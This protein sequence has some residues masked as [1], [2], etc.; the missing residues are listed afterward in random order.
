MYKEEWPAVGDVVMCRVVECV[1]SGSYVELLEYDNIIGM[2]GVT[3]YS[4]QRI[5][6]ISKLM[7]VG[8]ILPA[9]VLAVDK[10]NKYI[11]LSKK[12]LTLK[13]IE[14]CEA[15]FIKSKRVHSFVKHTAQIAC[16]HESKDDVN[17]D[18]KMLRVY[19]DVLWSKLGNCVNNTHTHIDDV[20]KQ[21]SDS[22]LAELCAGV[23]EK[24]IQALIAAKNK[25]YKLEPLTFVGEVTL[26]CYSIRGIEATQQ[27]LRQIKSEVQGLKITYSSNSTY[28]FAYTSDNYE[29]ACNLINT[30]MDRALLLMKIEPGGDGVIKERAVTPEEKLRKQHSMQIMSMRS[31]TPSSDESNDSDLDTPALE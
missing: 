7:N 25:V 22:Q 4:K 16:E 29:Y 23:D 3:Q 28:V 14:Q 26:V 27:I 24:V 8:K 17:V 10:Q 11:D 18:Q 9:Q 15:K 21:L 13:E 1:D 20:L 5:R 12:S 19:T 2:V 6:N 30:S 31:R